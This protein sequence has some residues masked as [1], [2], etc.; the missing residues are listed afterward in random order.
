[1][2]NGSLILISALFLQGCS[3]A[4][5]LTAPPQTNGIAIVEVRAETIEKEGWEG[6][7]TKVLDYLF[8]DKR[9]IS[10]AHVDLVYFSGVGPTRSDHQTKKLKS[11]PAN[12]VCSEVPPGSYRVS[13]I[14][15]HRLIEQEIKISGKSTPTVLPDFVHFDVFSEAGQEA[16]FELAP[17]QIT[18][19][20][21][22]VAR[23]NIDDG[24]STY[25]IERT[26]NDE[27]NALKKLLNKCEKTEWGSTIKERLAILEQDTAPSG[28]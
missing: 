17:G 21:K 16:T 6:G 10:Q 11:L 19:V 8:L 15:A 2:R 25:T 14:T 24:S 4:K 13:W 1:M 20:G 18:Y 23:R 28:K 3:T 22:L 12:F 7:V 5:L 9:I 26:L 27:I